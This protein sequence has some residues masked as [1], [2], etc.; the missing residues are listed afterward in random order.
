M[1]QEGQNILVKEITLHLQILSQFG[2][3]L[4]RLIIFL[5]TIVG[6]VN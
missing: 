5:Q 4:L 2:N 6:V 3:L 1:C